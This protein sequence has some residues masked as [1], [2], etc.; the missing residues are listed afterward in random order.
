MKLP[1]SYFPFGARPC[2]YAADGFAH[3]ASIRSLMAAC[4]GWD[5]EG[6]KEFL[7]RAPQGWRTCFENIHA[8]PPG[9]EL[10]E[11]AGRVELRRAAP[12]PRTPARTPQELVP[13]L[14]RAVAAVDADGRRAALALSGGLD[15]ALVLALAKRLGRE[16]PL[17]TLACHLP[18]YCERTP[19]LAA[20]QSL[21]VQVEVIEVTGEDFVA[22]LPNAVAAI[23]APLFNLHP[24]GRW[25]LARELHRRGYEVLI[26]GDGAD[27]LFAGSDPRN[28]LPWVG[29]LTRAAGLDLRSP[30]FDAGL[31][32]VAPEP[33]VGKPALVE[34]A[35]RVLP[36]GILNRPKT[37]CYAPPLDVSRHWNGSAIGALAARLG[38]E[39]AAPGGSAEAMLWTTLGLLARFFH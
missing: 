2:Y 13:H 24:V 3:G 8:V 1:A 5:L 21:G 33:A 35:R 16:I 29:A 38:L 32:A 12:L 11:R 23:G 17:F 15:S 26:T 30:F 37:P 10:V 6:V 19:T 34:A 31:A 7:A 28:Y 20:A 4:A 27:P 14:E 25:L 9:H 18:G 39:P 22:A 36:P